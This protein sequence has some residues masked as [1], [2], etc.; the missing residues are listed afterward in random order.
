[1]GLEW[2][3]NGKANDKPYIAHLHKKMKELEKENMYD[4]ALVSNYYK[5]IPVKR[6]FD[7]TPN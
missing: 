4:E 5:L 6:Y 7:K 3:H 2:K 1:M